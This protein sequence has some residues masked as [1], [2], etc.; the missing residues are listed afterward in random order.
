M[1]LT[2]IGIASGD[3]NSASLPEFSPAYRV[4]SSVQG[5]FYRLSCFLRTC[6]GPVAGR[7]NRPATGSLYIALC[8]HDDDGSKVQSSDGRF[9]S[10]RLYDSLP[11]LLSENQTDIGKHARDGHPPRETDFFLGIFYIVNLGDNAIGLE[12]GD[13][14]VKVPVEGFLAEKI[15]QS[16]TSAFL[17]D[18]ERLADKG[19]LIGIVTYLVIDEVAYYCI[20][21]LVREVKMAGIAFLEMTAVSYA[22]GF[23][24]ALTHLETVIPSWPPVI[25]AVALRLGESFRGSDS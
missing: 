11:L 12:T 23:C 9:V 13:S 22:F 6:N 4:Y 25:N 20:E 18:S 15:L 14:S 5:I 1:S 21:R 7:N 8:R 24:V 19:L 17:Q 3:L 10:L 16:E 2:D